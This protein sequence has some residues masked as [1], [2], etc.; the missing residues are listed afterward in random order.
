[1][2]RSMNID[3]HQSPRQETWTG[4]NLIFFSRVSGDT[5]TT[6]YNW[7]LPTK[8]PGA[9]LFSKSHSTFESMCDDL[10]EQHE[11]IDL[12]T[13]FPLLNFRENDEQRS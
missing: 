11:L 5:E 8:T 7:M 13:N 1:M 9:Y 4:E 6:V 12:A 10:F 2:M 3:N